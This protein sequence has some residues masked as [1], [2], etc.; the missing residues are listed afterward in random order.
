MLL[1]AVEFPILS[2]V[3]LLFVIGLMFLWAFLSQYACLASLNA[4]FVPW[5]WGKRGT[6]NANMEPKLAASFLLK[7]LLHYI[8]PPFKP[9]LIPNHTVQQ[10]QKKHPDAQSL[11]L[12]IPSQSPTTMPDFKPPIMENVGLISG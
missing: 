10:L 11:D 1:G 4:R 5:V 9:I 12:Q 3:L 7:G 8:V 2:V 6:R